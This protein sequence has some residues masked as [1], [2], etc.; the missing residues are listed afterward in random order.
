MRASVAENSNTPIS[1]LEELAE[2]DNDNVRKAVA[3]NP[4]TPAY[5]LE[6]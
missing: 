3:E 6:K 2:D 5:I 1:V 4:N